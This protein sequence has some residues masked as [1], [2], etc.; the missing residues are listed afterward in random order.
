MLLLSREK[1]ALIV[2][3]FNR[4]TKIIELEE[5]LRGMEEKLDDFIAV[6]EYLFLQIYS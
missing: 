5:L 2:F 3:K 1:W 4:D 6:N